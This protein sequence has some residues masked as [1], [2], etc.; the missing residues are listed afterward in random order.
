MS[1]LV[2]SENGQTPADAMVG[3]GCHLLLQVRCAVLDRKLDTLVREWYPRFRNQ[4]AI[5]VQAGF[6]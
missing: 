1:H 6:T 2:E 3:R 5:A 4:Q